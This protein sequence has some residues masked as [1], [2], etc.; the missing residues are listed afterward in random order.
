MPVENLT[1]IDQ[2]EEFDR[3]WSK[4][5]TPKDSTF[6]RCSKPLLNVNGK[7]RSLSETLAP[8]LGGRGYIWI[9]YARKAGHLPS[10]LGKLTLG[11][12]SFVWNL[13]ADGSLRLG[14]VCTPG[15][16]YRILAAN[17]NDRDA[18]SK[19]SMVQALHRTGC[20]IWVQL[21]QTLPSLKCH[22][23]IQISGTNQVSQQEPVATIQ[24][25]KSRLGCHGGCGRKLG[26]RK[27]RCKDTKSIR[28][29]RSHEIY[30]KKTLEFQQ[31]K[32]GMCKIEQWINEIY[33]V[34]AQNCGSMFSNIPSIVWCL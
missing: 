19:D 12:L 21:R 30:F 7:H 8:Y 6:E 10:A 14:L 5:I 18:E 29:V 1:D 33:L 24:Q 4:L 3:K 32:V 2:S 20:P 13:K 22:C 23:R 11:V 17:T 31:P 26:A 16:D 9:S 28:Y 15:F 34:V 25:D 27:A